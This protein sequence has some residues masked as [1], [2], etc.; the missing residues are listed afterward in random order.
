MM[1]GRIFAGVIALGLSIAPTAYAAKEPWP[2][3]PPPVV[4]PALDPGAEPRPVQFQRAII[5]MTEGQVWAKWGSDLLACGLKTDVRWDSRLNE[6][7]T[8]RF[9]SIFEGETAQAGMGGGAAPDLFQSGGEQGLQIGVVIKDIQARVCSLS[10]ENVETTFR[11]DVLMSAEWQV[12]DPTQRV[13]VARID[14][15][16]GV[17]AGRHARDGVEKATLAA[18]R[19]NVRALLATPA[20]RAL[21]LAKADPVARPASHAP[22][23]LASKSTAGTRKISDATG[24]VVAVFADSGHGSGFLVSEDGHLLTNRHVVGGSKFVKVRWSDGFETVGE[25]VRSDP[26]RDVALIKT[27]PHGRTPLA[28][29]R[30]AVQPGEMTYAI[31][32]P[33]DE[34]FQG[35]VTKGVISASR[36][37]DGFN[38]IQSDVTVN[39]G[40]SGGPL[41]DEN[42]GVVGIT[43]IGVRE[44]DAPTGINLFIPIGDALDFLNLKTAAAD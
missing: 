44:G 19:Q 39:P 36:I 20:Y 13:V 9:K 14:T 41:L 38:Y 24:S 21:V 10:A 12:F 35:T 5:R 43:V 42:G 7:D 30:G 3:I 37:L 16:A 40:N 4:V 11:A 22:I 23:T 6:L 31:G 28:L 15:V 25:V 26:R 17:K 8:I 29:R 1:K 34:K 27:D 32:T 33:L 18:F 2:L